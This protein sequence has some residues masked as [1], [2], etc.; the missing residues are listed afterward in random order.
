MQPDL[1]DDYR[2]RLWPLPQVLKTSANTERRLGVE[3]EF[4]GLD[5]EPIAQIV[6][7]CFGGE[8]HQLSDYE[9]K[10]ADTRHGDFVVELD[11]AYVKRLGRERQQAEGT[12]DLDDITESVVGLVAKQLVPFEIVCP[13]INMSDLWQLEG[14]FHRLRMQGAKGTEAAAKNAFGL[15]LNPEMPDCSAQTVLNYLRA[16]LCLYDWLKWR[17]KLDLSRR[18]TTYIDPFKRDYVRH[19]LQ[20][21]YQPDMATLMDDYLHYNPTR[22][23][24]LDLLPLFAHIDNDRLRAV[25]DDPR[26]KARPTLHYRL[27]NS[28]IDNSQWG[29]IIPW[30]DWL[31]VE[32]LATDPQ[33]LELICRA[34]RRHL[35]S[36]AAALFK[37][38]SEGVSRWLIPELL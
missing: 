3:I 33:R 18:F 13:P 8:V 16:F 5:I 26:V 19:V 7:D 29:L 25:I 2:K 10:V 20:A 11:S 31:Q 4:T 24:A 12:S 27:P 36:P 9:L 38:W 30:R 15:Q 28:L 32:G 21:E 14:M 37:D 35:D 6:K 17:S 22:N 1:D 34:Y 23:R